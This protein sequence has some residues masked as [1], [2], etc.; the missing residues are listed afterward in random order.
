[1]SL[2]PKTHI[3]V[4]EERYGLHAIDVLDPEMVSMSSHFFSY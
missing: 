2:D 3:V 4:P 1:M